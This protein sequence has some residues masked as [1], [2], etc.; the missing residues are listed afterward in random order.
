MQALW[1]LILYAAI[2]G[3][4]AQ[5]RGEVMY[6]NAHVRVLK[7]TLQAH[8]TIAQPGDRRDRV[9]IYL[10][11]GQMRRIALDGK[12]E[13]VL[14]KAGE[15]QWAPAAAGSVENAGGQA[16]QL[17][18]IELQGKAQPPVVVGELDP[19]KV[20]PKHYHLELENDRV[21]VLRVRFGPLENGLVHQHA[22]NYVVVYMT[23]QARGDR[24]DVRLHLD[25]G[26]VTHTEN[27]PLDQPVARIAV[28]LK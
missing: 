20:D 17:I 25:E 1:I 21:R 7:T 11:G 10:D 8:Q 26:T 14:V 9:V 2:A 27:N 13:T 4:S 16:V 15:V 24:G 22:R 18:A 12:A 23:K 28:E 6:D 5:A 19:L 3:F